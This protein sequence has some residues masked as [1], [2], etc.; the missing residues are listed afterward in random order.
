MYTIDGKEI[1]VI[2]IQ[3]DGRNMQLKIPEKYI[4]KRTTHEYFFTL[5]SQWK[6]TLSDNEY[7][8]KVT[9]LEL[10]K[11]FSKDMSYQIKKEV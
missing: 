4:S 3:I 9:A 2:N 1:A 6:Y 11:L 5:N 7:S 10:N 8:K